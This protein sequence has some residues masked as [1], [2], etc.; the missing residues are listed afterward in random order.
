MKERKSELDQKKRQM[1]I[2]KTGEM[3]IESVTWTLVCIDRKGKNL[4]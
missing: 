1:V 4:K 3:L 2:L